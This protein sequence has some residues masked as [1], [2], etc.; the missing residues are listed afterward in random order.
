MGAGACQTVNG[1]QALTG[2]HVWFLEAWLC[3]LAPPTHTTV[4]PS[5]GPLRA[6]CSGDVS[7]LGSTFD[8]LIKTHK[9]ARG[10]G[11]GEAG[12][13]GPARSLATQSMPRSLSGVCGGGC[14]SPLPP[15]CL[16]D[17]AGSDDAAAREP[18][19]RSTLEERAVR[20]VVWCGS[21]PPP[22]AR[23]LGPLS[24]PTAWTDWCVRARCAWGFSVPAAQGRPRPVSGRRQGRGPGQV[25]QRAHGGEAEAGRGPVLPHQRPAGV[26]ARGRPRPGCRCQGVCLCAFCLPPSWCSVLSSLSLSPLPSLLAVLPSLL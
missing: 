12:R 24:P 16:P 20:G 8:S 7:S 26:V 17:A 11:G 5:C 10:W 3:K 6:C 9:G 15:P 1:R 2:L 14:S 4:V 18:A 21:S 13:K 25:H 19:P 23:P 22:W